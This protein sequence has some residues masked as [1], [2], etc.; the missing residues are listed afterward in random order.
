MHRYAVSCV[1]TPLLN[2]P[3]FRCVFGGDNGAKLKKDA[4][5]LVR[6]LEMVALPGSTFTVYDDMGSN[7]VRV[8]THVYGA[9]GFAKLYAD[10]RFLTISESRFPD[11]ILQMPP[12]DVVL[13]RLYEANGSRYIWGGNYKAGLTEMLEYYPPAAQDGDIEYW[14]LKGVDCSGLLYEATGGVCPRNTRSLV[15][16]GEVVDI[17]GLTLERIISRARP[18]DCIV[19]PGHIVIFIEPGKI[20]QS[21]HNPLNRNKHHPD[22]VYIE[23]ARAVL[24]ELCS[25]KKPVNTYPDKTLGGMF[26]MRR[27]FN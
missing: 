6:E 20:I 15:D 21:R 3:D 2:T 23:D 4:V 13:G 25:N 7:I 22:G 9:G 18:L 17:E 16:Y 12:R 14:A 8:S 24:E 5:G 26:V 11:P 19:W 27:I 10:K 1:P